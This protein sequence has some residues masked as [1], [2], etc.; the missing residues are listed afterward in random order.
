MRYTTSWATSP[1]WSTS[2]LQA[3]GP[4]AGVLSIEPIHDKWEAFG[5]SVQRVDG[6]DV[7]ALVAA[8]DLAD[9]AADATGRPSVV[10]CDTKIGYGVPML[11]SREKAHF[12]R[13]EEHEW[14]LCRDQ[15]ISNAP[16]GIS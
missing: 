16:K 10:L 4:T 8:L 2:T 13:I 6:N 11:E 14:Q 15:L 3:D 5:W 12:M 9:A 7:P 1:P